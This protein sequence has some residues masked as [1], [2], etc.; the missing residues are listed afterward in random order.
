M[1]FGKHFSYYFIYVIDSINDIRDLLT[2]K[3]VK[4]LKFL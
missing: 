3:Y 4:K 1:C 2:Y